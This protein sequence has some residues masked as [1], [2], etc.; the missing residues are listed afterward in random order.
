MRKKLK[1]QKSF[2]FNSLKGTRM[3]Y[4]KKYSEKEKNKYK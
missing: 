2:L 4:E 3:G 1:T